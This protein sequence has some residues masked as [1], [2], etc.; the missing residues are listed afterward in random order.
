L[1]KPLLQ[2]EDALV[3]TKVSGQLAR[4]VKPPQSV[5]VA[6]AVGA[7][8]AAAPPTAA[9]ADPKLP[10]VQRELDKAKAAAADAELA[11]R[12]LKRLAAELDKAASATSGDD[13]AVA[14]VKALREQLDQQPGKIAEAVKRLSAASRAAFD[15]AGVPPSPQAAPLIDEARALEQQQKAGE[16]GLDALVQDS[17]KRAAK[18]VDQWSVDAQPLLDDAKLSLELGDL[19]AAGK[20]LARAA[21]RVRASGGKNEMFEEL[22]ARYYEARA[23]AAGDTADKR[24][25]LQ[26]A[27]AAYR[28]VVKLASGSRAQRARARATALDAEIRALE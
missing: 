27:Q 7:G 17:G 9:V 8:P 1:Y 4:L 3:R 13:A 2:D 22:S 12:E 25:L 16:T 5:V 19:D 10:A 15:A 24:K 14:E 6:A 11:V 23:D 21:K 28:N 20:S 18:F 26:Q